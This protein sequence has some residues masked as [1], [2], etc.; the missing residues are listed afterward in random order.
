MINT[1]PIFNF[2]RI[3]FYF[4]NVIFIYLNY[5]RVWKYDFMLLSG[6]YLTISFSSK[7][8]TLTVNPIVRPS[9][10]IWQVDKWIKELNDG[11]KKLYYFYFYKTA[12][13]VTLYINVIKVIRY[14]LSGENPFAWGNSMVYNSAHVKVGWEQMTQ[15]APQHRDLTIEALHFVLL[16]YKIVFLNE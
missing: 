16:F 3:I 13:S 4:K 5:K 7:V 14:L 15:R 8:V 11:I 6:N 12:Q 2:F 10:K 1:F 9:P